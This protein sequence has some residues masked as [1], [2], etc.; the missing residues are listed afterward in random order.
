M[1]I[2]QA[3][4]V[5]SSSAR[6]DPGAFY[7]A[8]AGLSLGA[9]LIIP[10]VE[11][12]TYQA[13]EDKFVVWS[14]SVLVLSHECDLDQDN[15][16]VLNDIAL[17]CPVRRLEAIVEMAE[18]SGY[19]DVDLKAFLSA[20]GSRSVN[21]AVYFPPLN[22]VLPYGG[23]IYLNQLTHTSVNRL[24]LPETKP[25]AALTSF[26][27]QSVDYALQQHLFRSK[28]EA[29]PLRMARIRHGSSITTR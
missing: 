24:S 12:P 25:I 27:M 21:R 17:I 2:A 18:T 9:G 11:F 19:S 26:A 20:L 6:D 4:K 1:E 10:N 5:V 8:C 3:H 16:R 28:A 22:D 14:G 23:F 7:G 13:D 15:K 29:L